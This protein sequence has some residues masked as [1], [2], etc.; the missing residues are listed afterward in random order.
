MGVVVGPG[1]GG[2]AG[3]VNFLDFFVPSVLDGCRLFLAGWFLVLY[4]WTN[5]E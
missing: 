3:G 2:G 1:G 4:C 5:R